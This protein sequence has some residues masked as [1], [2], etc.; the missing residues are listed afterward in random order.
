VKFN[1]DILNIDPAVETDYICEFL[2]NQ[3]SQ[4]YRRKGIVVGLSGGIDSAVMAALAARAVGA[5][6]VV[7]LIMPEKESNPVS[8]EFAEKHA[9]ELGIE[10][11]IVDVTSTVDSVGGYAWRDDYIKSLIPEYEPGYRYNIILP[12]DLLERAAFSIY[13]LQVEL[14]DGSSKRKRL[15]AD[16]FHTLTAFASIKI[17]ARMINLYWEAERRS[18][19]VTGTTNRTEMILGDFCKYG[20]GGTDTEAL[21]HLYKNQIYQLSH[22]LKVVPE[23]INRSPSPDTFSL[24]VSDQEFFFRIPFNRLDHLLY[25]W[26]HK[27]PA[28]ETAR[29]LE[30]PIDAVQRSYADFSAKSKATAHLREM[31]HEIPFED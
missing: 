17:R 15:G 22:Y 2:R 30:L 25:A 5:E 14:A 3:V 9:K 21:S 1:I 16:A 6:N 10:Y 18:R 8:S 13:T 11:R 28:E 29:I 27:V 26:E 7:G 20:D 31:P 19:I 12:G 4:V 24:P 23:I